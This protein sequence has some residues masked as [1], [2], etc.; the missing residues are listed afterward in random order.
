MR[1]PTAAI[2]SQGCV[3]KRLGHV[4][5]VLLDGEL[6]GADLLAPAAAGAVRGLARPGG[7]GAVVHHAVGVPAHAAVVVVQIE[8]GPHGDIFRTDLGT[9][10]AVGAVDLRLR[11]E[12]G[13]GLLNDL[14]L[15]LVQGDEVLHVGGVV[16]HLLHGGHA[17]EH[18]QH[19]VQAGGKPDAPGGDGQL[20][21]LPAHQL[22]RL[23]REMDQLAALHRLHDHH[24]LAVFHRRL[25]AGPGLDGFAVPVEV[26]QLQLDDLHLRVLGEDLVQHRRTVVEG[27]AQVADL[28]LVPQLFHLL[29]GVELLRLGVGGGVQGVEPVVVHIVGAQPLELLGKIPAGVPVVLQQEGGQLGGDGEGVPGM[30]VH[31]GRLDGLL[32]LSAVVDVGGVKVGEAPLQKFVRHFAERLEVHLVVL[33]VDDGQAHGAEA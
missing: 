10:A 30:P 2:G 13:R 32:A 33:P 31:Q 26:V 8:I 16:L 3:F 21:L 1:F 11:A 4:L 14:L 22:L 25:I 5:Q 24:L 12:D 15:L 19:V 23:R 7:E 17:G 27:E 29:K 6:L 9:L 28:P 18:H 20:R